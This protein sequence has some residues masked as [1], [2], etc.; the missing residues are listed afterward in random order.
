V[1]IAEVNGYAIYGGIGL[2][3]SGGYSMAKADCVVR[4]GMVVSGKGI[5]RADDLPP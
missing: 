5:T 1:V 4:G 3:W 2:K